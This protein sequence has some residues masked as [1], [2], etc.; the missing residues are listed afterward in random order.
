MTLDSGAFRPD[1]LRDPASGLGEAELIEILPAVRDLESLTRSSAAR[2]SDGFADLVMA[3][4]AAEPA[5]RMAGVFAR[6]RAHPGPAAL[7]TSVREAWAMAT[8]PGRA[9][10]TRAVAL[11]YVLTIAVV[12][13]SVGGAAAIGAAGFIDGLTP[14]RNPAPSLPV[15]ASPRPSTDPSIDPNRTNEP[16]ES[17][18]PE[19]SEEPSETEEPTGTAEPAETDDASPEPSTSPDESDGATDSPDP[20]AT[21]TPSESSDPSATPDGSDTP[22]PS[23]TPKPSETPH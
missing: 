18:E 21:P 6:L 3:A 13:A 8:R 22:D 7:A 12:G 5:P 17:D 15:D 20:S 4:I 11:A 19:T 1:E 9:F 14:D 10:G 16:D 2:P 23:D